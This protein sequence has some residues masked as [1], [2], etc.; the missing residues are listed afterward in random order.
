MHAAFKSRLFGATCLAVAF[1]LSVVGTAADS[2][3]QQSPFAGV[4]PQ[5]QNYPSGARLRANYEEVGGAARVPVAR[6]GMTAA[7]ASLGAA[8]EIQS[9]MPEGFTLGEG[10]TARIS[11]E[12]PAPSAAR[13]AARFEAAPEAG[14][15]RSP[16]RYVSLYPIEYQG[17]PLMKGSDY[18]AMVDEDGR[19][20]HTRERGLPTD[21]DASEPT[22]TPEAAV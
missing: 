14:P 1:G 15:D 11:G 3:A 17:I 18:L 4:A 16:T 20:L 8:A 12:M 9:R 22:V 6:T 13:P 5:E 21:V 19:L 7:A 2:L 10:T